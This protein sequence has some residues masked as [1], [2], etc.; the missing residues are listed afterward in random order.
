MQRVGG[1]LSLPCSGRRGLS[2]AAAAATV[3]KKRRRRV[4]RPRKAAI[5]LVRCETRVGRAIIIITELTGI[6]RP[7][8]AD[9]GGR[10]TSQTP[11]EHD[12]GGDGVHVQ[13]LSPPNCALSSGLFVRRAMH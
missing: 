8:G 12:Q 5:E 6:V 1:H 13:R 10:S 4:I 2:V 7:S 9:G 11:H 3:P